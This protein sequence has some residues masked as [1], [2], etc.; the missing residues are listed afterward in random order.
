MFSDLFKLYGRKRGVS[1]V[2]EQNPGGLCVYK[3]GSRSA[4]K[5]GLDKR[6]VD[7]I[8]SGRVSASQRDTRG[9]TRGTRQSPQGAQIPGT[10]EGHSL[11]LKAG[12]REAAT[13]GRPGH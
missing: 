1:L 3:R 2:E 9:Q 7:L 10:K 12:T 8:G 4:L 5:M 13:E 11:K 6:R